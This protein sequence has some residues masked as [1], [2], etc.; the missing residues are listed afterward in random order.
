MQAAA[1]PVTLQL[2]VFP[3]PTDA[4]PAEMLTAP[5]SRGSNPR[6][7]AKVET[8]LEA[9]A[10]ERVKAVVPPGVDE[11][12][13]SDRLCPNIAG[14]SIEMSRMNDAKKTE[15]RKEFLM[16]LLDDEE[17]RIVGCR[18]KCRSAPPVIA[19]SV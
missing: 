3:A 16:R 10:R 1:D 7:N 5:I 4:G 11:P 14:A 2:A 8:W 17:T 19:E 6:V 9:P 15:R 13:E 12:E 18:D